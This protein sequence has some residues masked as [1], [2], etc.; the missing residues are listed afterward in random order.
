M[1]HGRWSVKPVEGRSVVLFLSEQSKL[2]DS[3]CCDFF[4]AFQYLTSGC[5]CLIYSVI[6]LTRV[7]SVSVWVTW[8]CIG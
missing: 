7:V 4:L 6:K 5:F 3:K 2:G 1:H 8:A